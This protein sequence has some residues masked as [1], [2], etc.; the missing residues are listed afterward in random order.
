[1]PSFIEKEHRCNSAFSGLGQVFHLW[2]LENF[3]IIFLNEED[4][5]IGMGLMGMVACLFSDVQILTFEIMSNHLHLTATGTE[6]RVLQF[7]DC[8]KKV[9]SKVFIIMGRL[10]AWKSFTAR[11]RKIET[12]QDLRNVIIYN[13]RNGSVVSDEYT[14]F[15]YP[16]GANRYYYNPDIKQLAQ[17]LAKR[18]SV[19]E[20]R[21]MSHSHSFDKIH[22]LLS[23]EGYA[24]PLSFCSIE[25]GEK[26]FRDSSHYFNALSKNVESNKQIAKEIGE[27]VYYTDDELFSVI[28]KHSNENYS[29]PAPSLLPSAAKIE[30]AKLMH[31]EYNAS[32]KQLQRMLKL[33][34]SVVMSLG[35]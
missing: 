26:M 11:I 21:K 34:Q 7:F 32:A 33:P 15:T 16:W 22:N 28:V 2:T 24:M 5:K 30:L 6:T 9:L 27:S 25:T 4:F 18:M 8:F 12:L 3:E 35:F 23:F 13:N 1:M 14:P 17:R 19:R 10:V 31:N 29:I 20:M